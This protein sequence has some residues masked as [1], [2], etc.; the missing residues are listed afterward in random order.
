MTILSLVYNAIVVYHLITA[1]DLN[2]MIKLLMFFGSALLY[3]ID[4][5]ASRISDLIAYL[6]L[7]DIDDELK[8]KTKEG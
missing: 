8:D 1:E 7:K 5:F 6:C 3:S 4:N 2:I